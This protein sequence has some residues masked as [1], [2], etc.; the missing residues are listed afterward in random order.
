MKILE[1][2]AHEKDGIRAAKDL[3]SI[4]ALAI[5]GFW[6]YKAFIQKR[7]A[8][9]RAK[10]SFTILDYPVNEGNNVLRIQLDIE[11]IGESLMQISN[12]FARVQQVQPIAEVDGKKFDPIPDPETNEIPWPLVKEHEKKDHKVHREIEPGESDTLSFD[13]T[14]PSEIKRVYINIY[15]QNKKKKSK[16]YYAFYRKEIGWDFSTTHLIET[17]YETEEDHNGTS[18]AE[19]EAANSNST[20]E[21]KT[22]A[23]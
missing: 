10:G 11:N 3:F 18:E 5:G 20:G 13:F 14:I 1:L 23:S 15:I 19:T 4:L 21:A 9:P 8:F 22:E 6:A 16:W 2:L 12:H 17:T 7:M